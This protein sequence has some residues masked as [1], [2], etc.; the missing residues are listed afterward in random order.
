M[1]AVSLGSR[2]ASEGVA[3]GLAIS[4][5][6]DRPVAG[7]QARAHRRLPGVPWHLGRQGGDLPSRRPGAKGLAERAQQAPIYYPANSSYP[8]FKALT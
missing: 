3:A 5:L 2:G 6:R 1:Q 4:Y 8:L 7:G